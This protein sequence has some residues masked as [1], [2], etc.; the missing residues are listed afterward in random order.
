METTIRVKG[1][2]C[3]GITSTVENRMEKIMEHDMD[4]GV[5]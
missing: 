4:T 1:L 2:E 5:P 3:R